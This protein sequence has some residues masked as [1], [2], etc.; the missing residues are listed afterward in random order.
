MVVVPVHPVAAIELPVAISVCVS[1]GRHPGLGSVVVAF[2]DWLR[3][4]A[5][6]TIQSAILEALIFMSFKDIQRWAAVLPGRG[7]GQNSEIV[8]FGKWFPRTRHFPRALIITL[9]L[10]ESAS[11]HSMDTNRCQNGDHG[12]STS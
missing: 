1:V 6:L 4:Y 5:M 7:I 9:S 2:L 12:S 10:V 11:R 3:L 8:I